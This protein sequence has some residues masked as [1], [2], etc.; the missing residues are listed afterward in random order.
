[1]QLDRLTEVEAH[2][3]TLEEEIAR[4]I[5]PYPKQVANLDTIPGVDMNGAA[6]IIAEI[7]AD[8]TAFP[9]VEAA[10]AWASVAPGSNESAGKSRRAPARKGNIHLLTVLV[11]AAQAARNTKGTYLRDKY[12]RVKA[13][14]GAQRALVAIAHKILIAVYYILRDGV[15]YKDLRDTYLDKLDQTRVTRNLVRRLERLGHQV[16]LAQASPATATP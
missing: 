8:V 7:G 13:K 1:M 3:S 14:R 2:I 16:T 6:S 10:A 11:Q 12:Y 5:Q 4:R 15:P 9:T